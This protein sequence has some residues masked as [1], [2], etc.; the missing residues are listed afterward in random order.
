MKKQRGITLFGMLLV[1]VLVVLAVIV[2]AKL[3]PSYI[4]YWSVKKVLATMANDPEAQNMAPPQLRDS[5][6]KRATIADISSVGGKDLNISREG[7][8]LVIGVDYS[9]KIPLFGNMSAC[10]DFSGTTTQSGK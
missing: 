10:L 9:K 4:E 6:A 5:F 2:A 3:V 8:Q 7:G 1:A